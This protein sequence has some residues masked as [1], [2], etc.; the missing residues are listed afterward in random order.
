[1]ERRPPQWYSPAAPLTPAPPARLHHQAGGVAELE[2]LGADEA[3]AEAEALGDGAE[4]AGVLALALADAP[5]PPVAPPTELPPVPPPLA[6]PLVPPVGPAVG[7]PGV[8]FA[9]SR[10]VVPPTAA[11]APALGAAVVEGAGSPLR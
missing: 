7:A 6:L 11:A 2:L 8:G 10:S 5:P 3:G 4:E 1:M 9:P